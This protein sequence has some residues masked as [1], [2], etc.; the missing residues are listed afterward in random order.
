M[1]DG[2]YPI[3]VLR[4]TFMVSLLLS[5]PV[6]YGVAL[7]GFHVNSSFTPGFVVAG[8]FMLTC[9]V[10]FIALAVWPCP[11]CHRRFVRF[12]AFWPR[13]CSHCGQAC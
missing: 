4:L 7:I 13:S 5:G 1:A 11:Q 9:L 3:R 10:S 2:C 8:L 12:N 6:A